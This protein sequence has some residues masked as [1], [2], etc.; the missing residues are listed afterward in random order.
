VSEPEYS[1]SKNG[2][3]MYKFR[4]AVNDR[5]KNSEGEW[6]TVN[7]SF[8]SAAAFGDTADGL[9]MEGLAKGKAFHL[10][11]GKLVM[12]EW[13]DKQGNKRISP[14]VTIFEYEIPE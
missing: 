10:T 4:F 6:E 1:T 8:Y 2:K 11:N 3:P 12:E 13:E 7:S 5:R 9:A 14:N